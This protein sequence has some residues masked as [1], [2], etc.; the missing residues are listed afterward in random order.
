M[1]SK[2]L[3]STVLFCLI[4]VSCFSDTGWFPITLDNMVHSKCGENAGDELSDFLDDPSSAQDSWGHNVDE[5][6]W[7]IIDL[8]QTFT[9][10]KIKSLSSTAADP[11]DIDIY[12]S[13]NPAAMG[14]EV[15]SN[16][17]T[18]Q[19]TSTLVEVDITD[20]SGRYIQFEV[21]TTEDVTNSYIDWGNTSAGWEQLSVEVTI[22]DP[23]SGAYLR[24]NTNISNNW[25]AAGNDGF[26]DI[27]ECTTTSG[28]GN[29]STGGGAERG[30][31]QADKN[32]DS[33]VEEHGYTTAIITGTVSEIKIHTLGYVENAALQPTIDIYDGSSY[34]GSKTCAWG[35]SMSW[36]TLTW[37]GLSWNQTQLDALQ[38]KATA[39]SGIG[40]SDEHFLDAIYAEVTWTGGGATRRIILTTGS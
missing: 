16:I 32:D 7:F 1:L 10:S 11:T 4:S 9:I 39:S 6:H 29:K 13:D 36:K 5:A 19:D 33:A 22:A 25:A 37:S 28:I 17:S 21:D 40:A 30:Y 27:Y 3:I 23:A 8:G 38:V 12:M 34:E 2:I 31:H 18:I 15:H 26:R 35:T 20:G 14:S 24:P